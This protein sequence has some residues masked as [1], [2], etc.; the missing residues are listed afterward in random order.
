MATHVTSPQFVRVPS[1]ESTR[2]TSACAHQSP[3]NCEIVEVSEV[4]NHS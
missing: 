1:T 4:H 2:S 3:D